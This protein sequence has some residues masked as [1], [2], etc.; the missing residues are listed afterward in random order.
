MTK[1]EKTL[2]YIY[3]LLFLFLILWIYPSSAY[4]TFVLKNNKFKKIVVNNEIT[5]AKTSYLEKKELVE[6]TELKIV[7]QKEVPTGEFVKINYLGRYV[8]DKKVISKDLVYVDKYQATI[9]EI[10]CQK[11]TMYIYDKYEIKELTKIVDIII[12][13]TIYVEE[14]KLIPIVKKE[15]AKIENYESIYKYDQS[16]V[17]NPFQSNKYSL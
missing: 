16:S 4:D 1:T 13:E 15:I 17:K 9:C 7:G 6:K 3:L 14:V 12:L 8:Y 10:S 5:T 11:R 2:W